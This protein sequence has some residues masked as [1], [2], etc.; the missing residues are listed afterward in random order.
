MNSFSH[1]DRPGMRRC[2]H[3]WC[4]FAVLMAA[5]SAGAQEKPWHAPNHTHRAV[6]TVHERGDNDVNTATVR[7]RHAGIMRENANDLRLFNKAGERVPHHVSYHHPERDTLVSFRAQHTDST[8]FFYFG[9]QDAER[10][11][12]RVVQGDPLGI[13]PPHP[14]PAAS[15]WLPRAGI[16]LTTMRRPTD[17][18]N[19]DTVEQFTQLVNDSPA[20]DGAAYRNNIR[21][22]L[23][24]FGDSDH[25]LSLYHGWLRIPEHGEYVFCTASNEASFSFIDGKPLVHWPGRHTEKRGKLGQKNA[26]HTLKPGLHYVTYLHEEVLLYQVAFL[27]VKPPGKGRF[28][29]L[30]KR[31]VPQPHEAQVLRYERRGGT[32]TAMPRVELMDSVWPRDRDEG[33]YTRYRLRADAGTL[34]GDK[35]DNALASWSFEWKFGDGTRAAGREVEHVYLTTGDYRITLR[36]TPP[37]G[38]TIT[39]AWPLTVFPI[40]HLAGPFKRG[41]RA[42]HQP[43]V[44]RYD[45]DTLSVDALIALSHFHADAE[46]HGA[47]QRAAESALKR[48][49]LNAAQRRTLHLRAAGD[50]GTPANAWATKHSSAAA[51]HLQTAMEL[52][53][54]PAEQTRILARLIRTAKNPEQAR[55]LHDKARRAVQSQRMTRQ[56]R[57]AW[58]AATLATGDAHLAVQRLEQADRYYRDAEAMSRP[59]VPPQV[60][61]AQTGAY[62]HRI[63]AALADDRPDAAQTIATEWRTRFPVDL[64]SGAP[65]FWIGKAALARD[66]PGDAVEPMKLAIALGEGAPFEAEAYWRLAEAQAALGRDPARRHTLLELVDTGLTSEWRDK[67]VDALEQMR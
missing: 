2:L 63:A 39:R 27:G 51:E 21:D 25:Y 33:Q 46:R 40:E 67:A 34:N 13:Q 47:A 59:R 37:D 29:K 42:A 30:P 65:L 18:P 17:A 20:L 60:R 57:S 54:S 38:D 22:G 5:S 44:E 45:V 16:T 41:D 35:Q 62:P 55:S 48:E 36:A 12:Y 6:V 32:V 19:P 10:S 24:P 31:M 56:L 4:A 11:P 9:D 8:F 52:A 23:N 43:I 66:A 15:D 7:L 14:A 28:I 64:V 58:R 3:A 53:Q 1:H 61:H 26:A 49:N 50:V